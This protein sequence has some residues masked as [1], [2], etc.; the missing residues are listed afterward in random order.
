MAAVNGCFTKKAAGDAYET[1]QPFRLNGLDIDPTGTTVTLDRESRLVQFDGPFLFAL[2]GLDVQL[3]GPPQ[4]LDYG[5]TTQ[6]LQTPTGQGVFRAERLKGLAIPIAASFKAEST[7]GSTTLSLATQI[8]SNFSGKW[9]PEGYA[10]P[11][12][13][14]NKTLTDGTAT[15][16]TTNDAGVTELGLSVARESTIEAEAEPGTEKA[17][18]RFSLDE[19]HFSYVLKDQQWKTGAKLTWT[20]AK[21][22][23]DI[24]ADVLWSSAFSPL[25][26]SASADNIDRP[27]E[28]PLFLQRLNADLPVTQLVNGAPFSVSVGA[29][30][31]LLKRNE[32]T[33]TVN[34]AGREITLVPKEW[35]SVDGLLTVTDEDSGAFGDFGAFTLPT[36]TDT[37]IT[38]TL[39][40]K[41]FDQPVGKS[42]T[43]LLPGL[44]SMVMTGD[45]T[46]GDPFG[47]LQVSGRTRA[48]I[49]GLKSSVR[50]PLAPF[51]ADVTGTGR[52]K[53]PGLVVTDV[54]RAVVNG[55][56]MTIAGC[57]RIP[58]HEVG[59]AYRLGTTSIQVVGC[60]LS[61]YEGTP[62]SAFVS[63]AGRVRTFRVPEGVADVGLRITGASAMPRVRIEG[64]GGVRVESP[65][66]GIAGTAK[67]MLSAAPDD[68][69]VYAL[70]RGPR[71][72][73]WRITTLDGTV[74]RVGYARP[75]PDPRV[76]ATLSGDGCRP[77]VAYRMVRQPGQTVTLELRSALASRSL[78]AL[79]RARGTLRVDPVPGGGA[80]Q[81]L[82]HV[83]R[84]GIPSGDPLLL[85]RFDGS[86]PLRLAAPAD[87]R[88]AR[89]GASV[90]L[91]WAP[92]CGARSYLVRAGR[93]RARRVTR[94]AVRLRLRGRAR[95][96][97]VA[98]DAAGRGGAAATIVVSR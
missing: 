13:V 59:A 70:L 2:P 10:F 72:G 90:T 19:L 77:A 38:G 65:A 12:P 79:T 23:L 92:V 34:L 5:G 76:S 96:R 11:A 82:A 53:L 97:V 75:L 46:L 41:V 54:A 88:T 62:P 30:I 36:A 16:V 69:A 1:D 25:R 22:K 98:V 73:R 26:V 6:T 8:P 44:A 3:P 93:A 55:D 49:D 20:T 66:A 17:A 18:K 40:T 35:V 94:S 45:W 63:Q 89:R 37:A 28:P 91:R 80:Q 51:Y 14:K 71:A 33:K 15:L 24:T 85:A 84:N 7:E 21:S 67:A 68:K 64:P 47:V 32:S 43:L 29:G 57:V 50:A 56:Q 39:D 81:V 58:G 87:L 9:T 61:A 27:L 78:G 4:A 60:D 48:W 31:S 83:E 52:I 42:T 74:A 95:V 86:V